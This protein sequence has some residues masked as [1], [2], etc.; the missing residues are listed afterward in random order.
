MMPTA[1]QVQPHRVIIVS[2]RLPI[3]VESSGDRTTVRPSSGGLATAL[4]AALAGQPAVWVGW[5]GSSTAQLLPGAQT[6]SAESPFHLVQVTLTEEQIS[7]FYFG[8]SNEIIWPL[9]HDLQ[10]RCNFDPSYWSSYLEVNRTY[11]E[12]VSATSRPDDLVWVH[13]YHL[14]FVAHFLREREFRGR[15]GYFQHIPFP[16]PD[17]FSKL[18]W[19]REFL[20]AM[21]SYD[22]VGF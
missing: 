10:S 13:D 9:F 11:A 22:I 5:N 12:S 4:R 16:S 2:N 6:P 7:K 15:I 18:P 1:L 20:E 21:L 19:R 14:A 3:T 17:I 8:F